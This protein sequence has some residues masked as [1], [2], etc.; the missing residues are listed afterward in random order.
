MLGI[1]TA[2][3][4]GHDLLE[5]LILLVQVILLVSNLPWGVLH[6]VSLFSHTGGSNV[7]LSR[8]HLG[9]R[10]IFQTGSV[11]LL[12]LLIFRKRVLPLQLLLL[13]IV[14]TT[15]LLEVLALLLLCSLRD[16]INTHI[17]RSSIVL[18][19]TSLLLLSL[20]L[21][22]SSHLT[23][24]LAMASSTTVSYRE[25]SGCVNGWVRPLLW[26]LQ[27]SSLCSQN[28]LLHEVTIGPVM[29]Y[30]LVLLLLMHL[31]LH[32]SHMQAWVVN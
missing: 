15:V 14:G 27:S 30:E 26:L 22:G 32:N 13:K 16:Q 2:I 6:A 1:S 5:H 18:K 8:S 3:L 23:L 19:H 12:Q 17:G 7:L 21:S 31:L 10:T 29:I 11:L 28:L 20:Q 24:S 25:S 9:L 4:L